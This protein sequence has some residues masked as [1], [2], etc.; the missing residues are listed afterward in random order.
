MAEEYN[1]SP[2]REGA[3]AS[4]APIDLISR[5]QNRGRE[6][7]RGKL[8]NNLT[9]E[10]IVRLTAPQLRS[11]RRPRIPSATWVLGRGFCGGRIEHA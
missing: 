10:W 2:L 8:E 3:R 6:I 1:S 11:H 9:Y 5:P 7:V 4:I